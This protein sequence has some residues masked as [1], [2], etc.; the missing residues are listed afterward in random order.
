MTRE[1]LLLRGAGRLG[2]LVGLGFLA[3]L[4]LLRFGRPIFTQP[5]LA[6]ALLAALA[7]WAWWTRDRWWHAVAEL[8]V[9][10]IAFDGRRGKLPRFL[11]WSEIRA[12]ERAGERLTLR[13]STGPLVV[14][15]FDPEAFHAGVTAHLEAYRRRPRV[16]V[17]HRLLA[18][19]PD[20]GA[21]R[22]PSLPGDVLVRVA[23]DPGLD[24]ELRALAAELAVEAGE[25][26]AL[27]E[28]AEATADPAMRAYLDKLLG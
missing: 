12:V 2:P 7:V 26:R 28:L 10:G 24:D 1:R 4:L 19:D 15:P 11:R 8:G 20:E 25:R 13:T 6:A 27:E 18:E 3:A 9:D 16:E 23:A 17:P 22:D 5:L 14:E 21:Y